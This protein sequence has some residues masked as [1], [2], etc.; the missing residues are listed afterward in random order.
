MPSAVFEALADNSASW[1]CCNCGLPNF[2]SSLFN[3]FMVPTSNSFGSLSDPNRSSEPNSVSSSI[4]SPIGSPQLS[5]SPRNNAQTSKRGTKSSKTDSI[6]I[7]VLNAQSIM[8]KRQDAWVLIDSC[9]PDII[10]CS[11]TWLNSTVCDAEVL[12]P[13][14]I[15]YRND[16]KDGYGGVL[17]A[18]KRNL[19]SVDISADTGPAECETKAVK[20]M[21]NKQSVVVCGAYR[22]PN[23]D[24]QYHDSMCSYLENIAHSNPGATI[25]FAGDLNLPDIQWPSESITGHQY[26]RC[27][28]ERMLR[29]A[30]DLGFEQMVNFATRGNSILDVF[31]TNRPSLI[32]RCEPI[33]GVSDHHTAIFVDTEVVAP[34]GK[35]VRRRIYLW[36]KGNVTAL[37]S[38]IQEFAE[39]FVSHHTLHSSIDELWSLLKTKLLSAMDQFIPSKMST[40][41]F[42]QPWITRELKRLARR[43]KRKYRT[44]VKHN[45][46]NDWA[47]FHAVKKEMAKKCRVAYNDYINSIIGDPDVL[48]EQN[49]TYSNK[50]FFSYIKSI[51]AD[52]SGVTSLKKDGI[53][54]TDSKSK[55]QILNEYF[56]SVFTQELDILNDDPLGPSPYPDMPN[57]S[58]HKAGVVKLL[59][60][61]N[62][63][64]ASGPDQVPA[65]LFKELCDVVAPALT[66]VFQASLYQGKVP[67]DW[68]HALVTPLHKKGDRSN[69]SNYRPISLTSIACKCLEHIVHHQ[70][71]S[72]LNRSGILHD[73]QHGFR[74]GRSCESQLIL[75]IQDLAKGLDDG[76]QTDAILLD[77]SKA[78]DKVP[79]Q[80]LLYKLHH[81]GIRGQVLNWVAA[82]LAGRTQSVVCEGSASTVKPVVSGV[83]Q[84]TVLGP[85]LFL[86]Y[87][88]D[89][90]S[91]VRS[92]P[93]LFADDCLLYRRINTTSDCDILQNDLN[94]LQEWEAKW[95]MSFN[96]QKCEVLRV[97]RRTKNVIQSTYSIHNSTLKLVPSA[98]YL[99]VTID[100]KLNFNEHVNNICKKA[101]ATRAF[102]HRNTRSCPMKVKALAYKTFVRPQLEYASSVW[103]P[104]TQSNIDRIEAVQ[105]RAARSTV[106]DWSRPTNQP[107][108]I[109]APPRTVVKGS[110]SSILEYLGWESLEERRLRSRVTMMYRIVH[111]LVAI[112]VQPNLQLN[113]RDTRGHS[114][115]FLVPSARVD[116]YRFSFFPV[117]VTLWNSLPTDVVL[118][119]SVESFKNRVAAVQ[120]AAS[121]N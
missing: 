28:N 114:I 85:L 46:A 105:R 23:R 15:M 86:V 1:I 54:Y 6:K 101:N 27:I 19:G 120:L 18:V 17:V 16:R 80:R 108:L 113:T 104:H 69:P 13:G 12:P 61:L 7:V 110:A 2:S 51:R 119:P 74:K 118:A 41:R 76:A 117:T 32:K 103:A 3:S 94:R 56:S 73:A 40:I 121:T 29:T 107:A 99:G 102:V 53:V 44:A 26:P 93:R 109:S 4:E 75:A 59:R 88:N 39:D 106:N 57:I 64:K 115:K 98:K 83:P 112:P 72:H 58:V 24:V 20:I 97:T 68:S 95:L 30:S 60:G 5:S 45:T 92:T 63:H 84:G 81:C 47:N 79:H 52:S 35:N 111:E 49:S 42:N 36:D 96:P 8:A 90:P 66:F 62:I 11:E 70:I 48:D 89:L 87:I 33:P 77:F 116:A 55:A 31:M 50:K 82:F 38:D 25:W 22:P 71:M 14:Y 67:S 37:R 65:R 9:D 43:K 34:K 100:S 78:F 10:V 91:C 21:A